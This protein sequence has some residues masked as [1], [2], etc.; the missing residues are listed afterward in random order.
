MAGSARGS[1]SSFRTVLTASSSARR[2]PSHAFF[3]AERVVQM[4]AQHGNLFGQPKGLL[5][6]RDG[7]VV[8]WPG[9][10]R[11]EGALLSSGRGA[12]GGLLQAASTK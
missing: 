9:A 5:D 8:S 4:F 6:G 11:G 10:Q 12:R 3:S 7:P 2:R 1:S